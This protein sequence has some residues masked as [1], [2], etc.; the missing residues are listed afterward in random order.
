VNSW[1]KRSEWPLL[2]ASVLFLAAYALPILAPGLPDGW[3]V[4]CEVT[5]WV[6]WAVF[7]L[8]YLVRLRLAPQRGPWVRGHLL[9]LAVI[10]LP[11]LRPL[12]LLRLITVLRFMNRN[13]TATLRGRVALYVGGGST[14]L[15]LVA[16]LAA[17]DAE[18]T[19]PGASITTFG[20]ALWWAITTMTTV[21][22]GDIYP[23]TTSGRFVGAGLMVSGIA[24]LGTVTATFASWLVEAV[25]EE[26][27]ETDRELD[28]LRQEVARLASLIERDSTRPASDT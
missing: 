22:Y 18:R 28:G 23:V 9:D 5:Q 7:V 1:E 17:L 25:Q 13:A 16:A 26:V 10:A 24:L 12:R 14:L 15:A 20:D 2:A 11:L 19:A 27:T 6:V 21:G 3:V 4:T 8:D